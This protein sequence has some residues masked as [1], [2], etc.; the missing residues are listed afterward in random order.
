MRT[1]NDMMTADPDIIITSILDPTG[2]SLWDYIA[3][4]VKTSDPEADIPTGLDVARSLPQQQN[5]K[6]NNELCISLFDHMSE[7]TGHISAA[8][9]NLSSIV[10]CILWSSS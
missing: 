5:E 1:W 8:M 4:G 6:E 2:T 9:A 3:E 10:K 7:A